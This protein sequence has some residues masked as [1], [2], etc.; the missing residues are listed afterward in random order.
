MCDDIGQNSEVNFDEKT[1]GQINEKL[2]LLF[3]KL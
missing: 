1:C 3:L 2:A